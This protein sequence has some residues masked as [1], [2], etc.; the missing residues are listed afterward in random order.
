[1]HE[2]KTLH[3]IVDTNARSKSMSGISKEKCDMLLAIASLDRPIKQEIWDKVKTCHQR[4]SR[5]LLELSKICYSNNE[6]GKLVFDEFTREMLDTKGLLY[7]DFGLYVTDSVRENGI[8]EQLKGIAKEGISSGTLEFSNLITLVKSNSVAE[9]EN[10]VKQSEKAKRDQADA[11]NQT[12]QAQIESQEKISKETL[13]REDRNKPF[14]LVTSESFPVNKYYV[15]SELE[16]LIN[17]SMFPML[18]KILK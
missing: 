6:Q 5:H 8:L 4:G 3:R 12:A 7:T 11:Q 18:K 10:S 16:G 14:Y 13:D 2:N 17:E 1:M 9:V 15:E